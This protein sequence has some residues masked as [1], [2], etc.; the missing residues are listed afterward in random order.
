MY[1][2]L[3]QLY[4]YKISKKPENLSMLQV[5]QTDIIGLNV[6]DGHKKWGKGW[7]I[8]LLPRFYKGLENRFGGAKQLLFFSCSRILSCWPNS[9]KRES[10]PCMQYEV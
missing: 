3:K 7:V 6:R 10:T 9:E 2:N 5:W 4:N 8:D 1:Y